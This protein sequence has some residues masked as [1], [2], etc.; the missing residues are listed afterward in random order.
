MAPEWG[1]NECGATSAVGDPKR[2]ARTEQT[3]GAGGVASARAV[4]SGESLLGEDDPRRRVRARRR[5]T[6]R[7]HA[8]VERADHGLLPRPTT[9]A[10]SPPPCRPRTASA[11]DG[12]RGR[13]RRATRAA[14]RASPYAIEVMSRTGWGRGA[15]EASRRHSGSPTPT[16]R[17]QRRRRRFVVVAVACGHLAVPRAGAVVGSSNCRRRRH[18]ETIDGDGVNVGLVPR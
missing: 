8:G 1:S 16:E 7:A 15:Q 4:C 9:R 18:A 14:R 17:R 12:P 13:R 5:E 2:S 3:N 11:R 10:T 6:H